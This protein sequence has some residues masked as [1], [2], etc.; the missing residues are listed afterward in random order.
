[1]SA[2]LKTY[3]ER[4]PVRFVAGFKHKTDLDCEFHSHPELEIVYHVRG[5]GTTGLRDG[6]TF[7]F[8]PH[9]VI[10]YGPQIEHDQLMP[11]PG[12]DA[13]IHLAIPTG[14]RLEMDDCIY[15][16]PVRDPYLQNELN[17]LSEAGR[18]VPPMEQLCLD[19]RATALLVKLLQVSAAQ[20]LLD[21][22]PAAETYAAQARDYI[23]QHFRKIER[24][25]TIADHIGVSY[26][27]LRHVFKKRYGQNI[28]R[29][30][31]STRI[32]EAKKLLLHSPLPQKAIAEMCGFDNERYFCTSFRNLA[33]Q[34]PGQFRRA[35]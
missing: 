20:V 32:E 16:P 25:E 33:G 17:L 4:H 6:R 28:Q 1:M 10:I 35:R 27:Y 11:G 2:A 24:I 19:Y 29:Y 26:H 8:E 7:A 31:M 3:F 12:E 21:Q 23:H 22:R 34:T 14:A 15:V 9:G 18:W 30:L 5:T 13:C